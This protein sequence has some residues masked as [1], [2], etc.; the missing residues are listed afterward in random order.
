VQQTSM[1]IQLHCTLHKPASSLIPLVALCHLPMLLQLFS[2]TKFGLCR[3]A[4]WILLLCYLHLGTC[5]G[6]W[7]AAAAGAATATTAVTILLAPSAVQRRSRNTCAAILA[8]VD[9]LQP[10]VVAGC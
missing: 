8:T 9:A 5:R 10:A 4:P 3:T 1:R 2:S 6:R 7:V